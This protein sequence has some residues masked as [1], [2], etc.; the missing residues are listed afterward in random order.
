[1]QNVVKLTRFGT[2][3]HARA[4]AAEAAAPWALRRTTALC[5]GNSGVEIACLRSTVLQTRHITVAGPRTVALQRAAP[6]R[7]RVEQPAWRSLQPPLAARRATALDDGRT[8]PTGRP[9]QPQRTLAHCV[10]AV[11]PH[12]TLAQDRAKSQPKPGSVNQP[13][14]WTA[15]STARPAEVWKGA[16]DALDCEEQQHVEPSATQIALD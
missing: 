8:Y 4:R 11:F 15:T 13:A 6:R 9:R 7:L 3:L 2:P 5:L 14:G 12:C 1:M 16:R 10:P